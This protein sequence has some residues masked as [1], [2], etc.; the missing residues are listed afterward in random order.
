[1][2]LGRS[3]NEYTEKSEEIIS[4]AIYDEKILCALCLKQMRRHSTYDREI[5]ETGE[6]ITITV[7]WCRK[8]EKWHSLIPDFL[9]PNKHYSG[10]EIEGVIID[11][12]VGAVSHIDTNASESTIRRWIKQIGGR[13]VEAVGKLKLRFGRDGQAVSEVAIDAGHCYSELEQILEMAPRPIKCSG[14]KLGLANIWLRISGTA[15]YI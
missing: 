15:S 13:I 2:Y 10:N 9:L 3:V 7:V 5:K 11:S 6:E 8:C 14:N 4:Q 12:A 1:M